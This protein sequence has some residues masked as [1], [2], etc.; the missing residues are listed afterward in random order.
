MRR[1]LNALGV[2][3]LGL[4]LAAG[5][6]SAQTAPDA[7][8]PRR[9][10]PELAPGGRPD[11]DAPFWRE[12]RSGQQGYVSIPNKAAGTLVQSD[13]ESWRKFRNGPYRTWSGYILLGTVAL[14]SL[15]FALR[16]RIG[17]EEG[18]PATG[19]SAST[20]SSGSRTG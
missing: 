4:L 13:G 18:A 15:F 16:G 14:L 8:A 7:P 6:A 11:N 17:I 19:S 12:V 2:M 9:C 1:M 5:P 3:L 20:A 10:A